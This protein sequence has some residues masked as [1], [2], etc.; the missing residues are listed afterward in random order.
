M[1]GN[2]HV[3]FGGRPG[4][5]DQPKDRH[6]APGPPNL[7]KVR[8]RGHVYPKALVIA[9]SVHETGRREVIGL[10]IGEIET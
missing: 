3:R 10:D 9:Y 7:V 6:R 2:A 5:T 4:E 8:D 1:R